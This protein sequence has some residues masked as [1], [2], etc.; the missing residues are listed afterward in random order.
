VKDIS[1]AATLAL[2]DR[3]SQAQERASRELVQR[4]R[5][6]PRR[7]PRDFC[8]QLGQASLVV[9]GEEESQPND[10]ALT[11]SFR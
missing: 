3:Y 11:E 8:E 1:P 4:G 2:A 6:Q 9:V 5:P 7:S 10:V